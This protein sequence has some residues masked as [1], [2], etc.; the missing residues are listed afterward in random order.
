MRQARV[1]TRVRCFFT[2]YDFREGKNSDFSYTSV[3]TKLRGTRRA[4][5]A[6]YPLHDAR[7]KPVFCLD[8]LLSF[9]AVH[10]GGAGP[11]PPPM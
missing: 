8:V 2:G 10:P 6:C 7:Q 1:C 4:A 3:G 9:Q 11:E 5:S